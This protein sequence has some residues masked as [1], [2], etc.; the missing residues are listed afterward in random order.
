MAKVYT[1][2]QWDEIWEEGLQT[3]KITYHYDDVECVSIWQHP[4]KKGRFHETSLCPGLR[5]EIFNFEN[6]EIHGCDSVDSNYRTVSLVFRS[7]GIWREQIFGVNEDACEQPGE[8]YLFSFETGT[9]EI[10][11]FM[12]GRDINIRIRLEPQL[13]RLLSK[14]QE[15]YLP[16]LLKPFLETDKPPS[17]YQSLGKMTP[18]MQVA[19]QQILQCPFQG[20]MRRTYLEAKTLELIT[21]QFAQL[22]QDGTPYK[23]SVNIKKGDIERIYQARDILLQNITNPPSLIELARQVELNDRKLKQGFRQLLGTTVFGY[24]HDYRLEKACQFLMEGQMNV[25]QVSYAVGFANRGYFA[26]AFR[27]KFGINPSDYQAQ[28]RKKS[29]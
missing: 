5:I 19:L 27:K 1:S 26:A 20:I 17:F 16:S 6:P 18:A 4:L 21:L 7:S 29:G 11:K 12:A 25:A 22:F 3:G 23:Q 13:L 8:S 10:E 28:W 15:A 9:R 2:V 14:G 24:L